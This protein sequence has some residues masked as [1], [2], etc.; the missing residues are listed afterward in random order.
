[1]L[2][3]TKRLI[4][5]ILVN[6]YTGKYLALLFSNIIPFYGL[7]IDISNPIIRKKIAASLCFK[8][9]ESAEVRFIS[10][11]L[12]NFEGTI[13]E[14]GASIGVVS[15]T[16]AC[17]NPKSKLYSFEAD[18]RFIQIIKNN[19]KINSIV[20]AEV[21]NEIIGSEG[22][23]FS[24]GE[25]NTTGKISKGN[26]LNNQMI[27]LPGILEKYEISDFV[28]VSDIEGAEYFVL[29][30][31]K[32]YFDNCS[33]IIIELHPI[34]IDGKLIMVEDLKISIQNLGYT[35][36]EQYGANIVAKK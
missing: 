26:S 15:C 24:P 28:L 36:L 23:V 3:K 25:D 4:A 32:S 9:Y 33:M 34:E 27:S 22:F 16:I 5:K 10:K 8:T 13:I 31:E 21:Y 14:F 35:I 20:N 6:D 19:F 30:V 11:Y 17:K 29:N 1:M 2:L 18:S 12:N 7:K